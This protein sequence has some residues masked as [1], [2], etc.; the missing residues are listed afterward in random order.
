[1]GEILGGKK[2]PRRPHILKGTKSSSRPRNIIYFDSEAKITD[3]MSEEHIK[4]VLHGQLV[5]K[6]HD[7]YLICAC[8]ERFN[9]NEKWIDYYGENFYFN[10]W[11]DVEKFA[12]Y[13]QSTYIFA[14]NAKY[15]ILATR[16]IPSLISLG[17]KITSFS[18]DK[19]LI[20]ELEKHSENKKVKKIIILSSTNYYQASIK[21]LG[22]TFNL[23]KLDPGYNAPLEIAIQ[24][25][26]R[27]VE[28]VKIAMT[29]FFDFVVNNKLGNC[30][31]TIAGQS[32]A[33]YRA[34]FMSHEIGIHCDEIALTV[35][36][37]AYSGGR[38]EAW[39]I[40]E[41]REK[42][43][44]VD[45]NSMYPFVMRVNNFPVKL[46]T[47][48]NKL[49]PSKLQWFIDNNYL[50]CAR[51]KI[52]T[53][54]PIFPLK[55]KGKLIFPIGEFVTSIS[56]PEIIK[57][58]EINAIQEAKTVCVYEGANIFEDFVTFFYTERLKAKK[59]KD[60][61]RSYLLKIF[62]NSLYG[63]FG[64]KAIEWEEIGTAPPEEIKIERIFSAD[65]GTYK[66][67][68]II[69]GLILQNVEKSGNA[70][71][72]YNSFPAIAAHVT[73]YARCLLWEYIQIAGK[74][75]VYYMDTD[76]IFCNIKGYNNLKNAGVIDDNELGMLCLDKEGYFEI[77]GLKDY[78]F[79]GIDGI[80]KQK[81]KGVN[82]RGIE[83]GNTIA[84]DN[85][86]FITTVWPGISRTIHDNKLNKNYANKLQL[87]T[88]SRNYTKGTVLKSGKVKPFLLKGENH[89][90]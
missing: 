24:Y 81:I 29:N 8:F 90:A 37:E 72:S 87:K 44:V 18:E 43:F 23:P 22:E 35:E 59:E 2:R 80:K 9:R 85:N 70:A 63:K 25:C 52:K 66:T 79:T 68:K 78:S 36:R 11:H 69:G 73:A 17:F 48:R 47:I 71:E 76:S 10:F 31:R 4:L 27:D 88:L 62:M 74:A 40:G 55:S 38:T 21:E 32:F 51:C 50:L 5:E 49:S 45:V 57:A 46:L 83:T 89:F 30:A 61:V 28:I 34:R 86:T 20:I 77:R 7:T 65:T 33:A 60:E 64:Q 67:I 1:M 53:K 41:I 15:D 12:Q 19:P 54:E 42:I 82:L 16:A 6:E 39:F 58:L 56:T 75:N 26:R 84:I 13:G 14:H 3:G